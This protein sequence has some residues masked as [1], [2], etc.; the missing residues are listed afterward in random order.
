MVGLLLVA[1]VLAP[2][3]L[4]RAKPISV[5]LYA[6]LSAFCHQDPSRGFLLAGLP[7]ALCSRCIGALMGVATGLTIS[8]GLTTPT[9]LRLLILAAA[10]WLGEALTAEWPAVVRLF[11]GAPI[12]LALAAPIVDTSRQPTLW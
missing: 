3:T 10:A 12:G 6:S 9:I 1:A 11:A 2:L 8:L 4:T 7:T 5:A